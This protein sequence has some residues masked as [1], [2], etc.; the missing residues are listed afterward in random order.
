MMRLNRSFCPMDLALKAGNKVLPHRGM[1][2]AETAEA[3]EAAEA[4]EMA[5]VDLVVVV[6]VVVNSKSLRGTA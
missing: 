2:T 4:A 1:E 3:A 5:V 6:R